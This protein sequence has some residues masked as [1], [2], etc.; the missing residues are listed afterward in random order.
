MESPSP[1][2]IRI[3]DADAGADY[4]RVASGP[5]GLLE[6]GKPATFVKIGIS[7]SSTYVDKAV[8]AND[9]LWYRVVSFDKEGNRSTASNTAQTVVGDD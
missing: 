3:Q 2:L 6:K 8:N 9:Q 1:P 7:N 5:V 4:D